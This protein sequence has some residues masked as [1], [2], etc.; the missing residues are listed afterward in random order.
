MKKK[1]LMVALLFTLSLIGCADKKGIVIANSK[2]PLDYGNANNNGAT[3]NGGQYE[4]VDKYG[5][6]GVVGGEYSDNSSYGNG[7]G[8]QNIYFGVDQYTIGSDKL[9]V[10]NNNAKI[11][12]GSR[13]KIE[14]HCDATGTDEYN[15]ALG[16]RRAKAAKEAIANR[17]IKASNITIVSMGESSPECTTG[18]SSDCFAKNRRVEFKKI[19]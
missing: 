2:Q 15:Y 9:Y 6:N 14:G 1:S 11:L 12:K 10:I 16:L 7:S 5:S 4:N 3:I 13:V 17:G 8:V 19:R 18:F